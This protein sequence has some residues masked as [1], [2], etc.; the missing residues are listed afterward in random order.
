M[1]LDPH[2]LRI[3]HGIRDGADV[4][5]HETAS[6]LRAL[7]RDHPDWLVICKAQGEYG[8]HQQHPYF[9]AILTDAG[10]AFL[11]TL[12]QPEEVTP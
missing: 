4:F 6:I 8:P 5:S 9:G 11:D 1:T 2:I 12:P 10:R 3:L 7:K